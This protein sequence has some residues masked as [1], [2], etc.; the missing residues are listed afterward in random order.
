[1]EAPASHDPAVERDARLCPECLSYASV[2]VLS[3]E[4]PA[5]RDRRSRP[6]LKA[7]PWLGP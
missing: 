1:L 6:K 7:Y 2:P 5:E 4:E 3:D